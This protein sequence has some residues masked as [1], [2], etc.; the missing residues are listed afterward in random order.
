MAS[1][2]ADA[3]KG[4]KGKRGK[5]P[6]SC[7]SSQHSVGPT[8]SEGDLASGSSTAP[9]PSAG[10]STSSGPRPDPYDSWPDPNSSPYINW[11]P[12]QID[13]SGF[14][15]RKR[16]WICLICF[17]GYQQRFSTRK[18]M[19]KH[20]RDDHDVLQDYWAKGFCRR[21]ARCEV[22]GEFLLMGWLIQGKLL[23][24]NHAFWF[25]SLQAGL[26]AAFTTSW[27]TPWKNMRK[28]ESVSRACYSLLTARH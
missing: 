20:I 7:S 4:K 3:G 9:D 23:E 15:F 26:I 18:M 11:D 21:L 22:C 24:N 25:I 17:K 10:P 8:V 27:C 13:Q 16:K 14:P 12:V 2:S 6:S 1:S 19:K 28:R 5:G